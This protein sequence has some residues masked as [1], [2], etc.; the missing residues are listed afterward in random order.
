[1]PEQ[2]PTI[3]DPAL[4]MLKSEQMAL[5]PSSTPSSPTPSNGMDIASRASPTLTIL[6]MRQKAVNVRQ[7]LIEAELKL[8]QQEMKEL[9]FLEAEGNILDFLASMATRWWEGMNQ[10]ASLIWLCR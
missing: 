1:M 7:R 8:K 9:T 6:E 5:D 3:S 4:S 10:N 2:K